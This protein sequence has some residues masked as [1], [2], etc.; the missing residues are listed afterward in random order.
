MV[1]MIIEKLI[2]YSDRIISVGALITALVVIFNRAIRPIFFKILG[3]GTLA[4]DL[5]FIVKE[6]KPNGGSSLRDVVNRIQIAQEKK[7]LLL[8][9]LLLDYEHG[10]FEC[11]AAGICIW[12]NLKMNQVAGTNMLG[13]DWIGAI[14]P[15]QRNEFRAEW[16]ASLVDKRTLVSNVE[17]VHEDGDRVKVNCKIRPMRGASGE[18]IGW[19]GTC[20]PVNIHL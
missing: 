11:D 15:Q 3:I 18:V 10:I 16:L 12:A 7:T 20:V 17:F 8:Y 14:A 4:S 19:L 1:S 9:T 6:F 13:A 2:F 5:S